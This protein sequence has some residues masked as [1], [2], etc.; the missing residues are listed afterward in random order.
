MNRG[1]RHQIRDWVL[2]YKDLE[3]GGDLF[4]LWLD[5]K[6]AVVQFVLGP[7]E[8][9]SRTTTSFFQVGFY[10][11]SNVCCDWRVL[12]VLENGLICKGTTTL[13]NVYMTL[14]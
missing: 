3:T 8:N 12:S 14:R 4:G 2:K 11:D 9:C 13:N 7:G 6:T 5:A 10:S 1:E